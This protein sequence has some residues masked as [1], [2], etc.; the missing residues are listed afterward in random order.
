MEP[1]GISAHVS[2]GSALGAL[3]VGAALQERMAELQ[4]APS[5][6]C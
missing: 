6:G 5:A 1:G 2:L 3:T 4:T